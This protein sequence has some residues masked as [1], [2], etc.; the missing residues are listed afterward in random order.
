MIGVNVIC[1]GRTVLPSAVGIVAAL[2]AVP[3]SIIAA[4]QCRH[5]SANG[6]CHIHLMHCRIFSSVTVL[7]CVRCHISESSYYEP[8]LIR[9][10]LTD[11]A[12]ICPSPPLLTLTVM[13]TG[14]VLL[15]VVA[16]AWR[17]ALKTLTLNDFSGQ[18]LTEFCASML[19]PDFDNPRRGERGSSA[20]E[21]KLIA[22][23]LI[24]PARIR[25]PAHCPSCLLNALDV[26]SSLP[27]NAVFRR[28]VPLLS[29]SVPLV[30]HQRT[31]I[32]NGC[33]G[34]SGMTYSFHS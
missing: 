12:I 2:F 14:I 16:A 33:G 1:P 10:P 26:C 24:L 23:P 25:N 31:A 11:S 13:L 27:L 5:I 4:A 18:C 15:V 29:E 19:L 28:Q 32:T 9:H 17:L 3:S 22:Q 6:W 20:T 7:N 8:H 34:H 21:W 30:N